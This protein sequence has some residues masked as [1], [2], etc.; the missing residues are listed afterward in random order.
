M[1]G[2]KIRLSLMVTKRSFTGQTASISN[3]ESFIWMVSFGFVYNNCFQFS[4]LT[5]VIIEKQSI[6]TLLPSSKGFNNYHLQAIN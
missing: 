4:R 6:A 5:I 2:L 3:L 1:Q